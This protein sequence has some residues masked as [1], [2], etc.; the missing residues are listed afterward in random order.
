M[1]AVITALVAKV[2][3][4]TSEVSAGSARV[5]KDAA[6]VSR[7]FRSMET[8]TDKLEKKVRALHNQYKRG[9]ITA[10]QYRKGLDHLGSTLKK[11]NV[12]VKGVSSAF[13]FLSP[14]VLAASAAM[15]A[16][17]GTGRLI[18][19]SIKL[20]AELEEV[21]VQFEVLTG[22]A[23]DADR[24]VSS[25]RT[26]ANTTSLTFSGLQQNARTMLAFGVATERVLPALDQIGNITM[27]N[28]DR[29]QS[30]S[31]AY[32][33]T[34]SAGKLMGQDLLQM[35]NAGFNPLQ[36]ISRKTGIT[37]T[38][39]RKEMEKGAISADLVAMAF[40][41]AT[42]K[43]G[44]FDDMLNKSKNTFSGQMRQ[45]RSDIEVISTQI[46][47]SLLPAVK[48]L[49]AAINS[50]KTD[51]LKG[52]VKVTSFFAK[53]EVQA[54]KVLNPN[55]PVVKGLE[56]ILNLPIGDSIDG[57]GKSLVAAKDLTNEMNKA[58]NSGQSTAFADATKELRDQIDLLRMGEKA[59]EQQELYAQGLVF[60]E[61]EQIQALKDQLALLKQQQEQREAAA[62]A[63]KKQADEARRAMD[64]LRKQGQ[65]LMEDNNP[66]RAVAKQIADLNVLLRVNAIDQATYFKERNKILKDSVGS[67]GDTE[68]PAAINVGSQESIK[69]LT[70]QMNDKVDQQIQK[71]EEQ[72]LLAVAQLKAQEL[73]NQ[74]LFELGVMRK[75][76]P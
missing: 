32:A 12:A 58:L 57:I 39:L 74:R 53:L 50:I 70:G 17:Y 4:D 67:L 18:Q 40:E 73:T 22:S 63:A 44:S 19:N 66:V 71:A 28:R 20:A 51:P 2:R 45:I 15:G 33:Q 72:R 1:S 24:L 55:S 60:K 27:G 7:V 3:M 48:E 30:L 65:S 75:A 9:A 69:L 38:Q 46:G 16:F 68:N 64:D 54:A 21:G 42:S 35:V 37:I 8:D 34:A 6:I 11:Q 62:E 56:A 10:K 41:S 49:A 14:Q 36:E 5:R 23:Q 26:L 29:M 52:V 76:R 61:V 59:F 43:G 47:E 25:M 31:L 13:S